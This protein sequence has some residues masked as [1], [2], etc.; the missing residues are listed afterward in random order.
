MAELTHVH[1]ED[2]A[3]SSDT[4]ST[5][6]LTISGAS[7]TANTKYLAICR[8]LGG[9]DN[10]LDRHVWQL[11]SVDDASLGAYL[12]HSVEA[13]ENTSTGLHA[14]FLVR[15][16]KT[17]ASPGDVTLDVSQP[18]GG[19]QYTDQMSLVLLD[20]DAIGESGHWDGSVTD[21]DGV[22]TNDSNIAD[23]DESTL[24]SVATTGTATTNEIRI[25]G[26]THPTS[27]DVLLPVTVQFLVGITSASVV[28]FEI[29]D[30]GD[31]LVSGTFVVENSGAN[32]ETWSAPINIP[33]PS[34]GWTAAKMEGLTAVVW[35]STGTGTL[36]V[37]QVDFRTGYVEHIAAHYADL[38]NTDSG[39]DGEYSST[40]DTTIV[41]QL[42]GAA[43]G[44]DEYLILGG[45]KVN[46]N[47]AGRWYSHRLHA[48]Y[49][50]STA[51]VRS[52]VQAEGEDTS[53]ER[54]SGFAIRHK[55]SSGTPDV[56][57]YG[58]EEAANANH[59]DF[60][61]YLIALPTS[62]FA[63]FVDDYEAGS[64]VIDG[65]ETTIATT[66]SYTPTVTGN[67]LIFGRSNGVGPP[68]ALGGMWVE[69]TTTEIRTGDS[70]P[71]QN[72][73]WDDTKDQEQQ[74]T[75][76]RYA[77]TTAETFNL[78]SQ[79][80]GVDFDQEHRWLIVVNLNPPGAG[81]TTVTP[82]VITSTSTVPTPT[83][84]AAAKIVL[85]T[86]IIA[87]SLLP[88]PTA[89]A[90][91]IVNP[92]AIVSTS[93]VPTPT[94]LAAATV[95]P[96]VITSTGLL[97]TPTASAE[98]TTDIIQSSF[99]WRD[100]DPTGINAN[101][102]GD[103]AAAKD[104]DVTEP[105]QDIDPV[106]GRVRIGLRNLSGG[107]ID[108]AYELQYSKDGGSWQIVPLMADPWGGGSVQREVGLA[109]SASFVNG[110]ATTE[111]LSD[112][113][114][115][116]AGEGRETNPTGSI[117]LLT[118]EDTEL[119][120]KLIFRK[121]SQDGHAGD[122]TTFDFRVRD[123]TAGQLLGTYTEIPRLTIGNQV[124]HIGGAFVE[125]PGRTL[126]AD[127]DGNL[128]AL[129]EPTD[130]EGG[131]FEN[132]LVITKSA[133]GG[134]SWTAPDLANRPGVTFQD[135]E[136]GDMHY[137]AADDRIYIGWHTG[138]TAHYVEF[139][140]AGH[141]SPDEYGTVE[142]ID[143][144]ITG[145]GQQTITI[146]RRASDGVTK[147]I[148]S[149]H[150]GTDQRLSLKS[151]TSGGTWDGSPTDV[152]GEAAPIFAIGG[153]WAEIDS[154]NVIHMI[155]AL[156]PG[157]ATDGV[158]YH[159]EISTG[160]SLSG[161]TQVNDGGT[162]LDGN[163]LQW[164]HPF[165]PPV[166]YND[167]ATEKIA[168]LIY[169]S[170]NALHFTESPLDTISFITDEAVSDSD[171]AQN[172]GTNHMV[173]AALAVDDVDDEFIAVWTNRSDKTL[174]KT[175][176][177][178]SAGSWGTD[179]TELDAPFDVAWER[180]ITFTHSSGNGGNRVVGIMYDVHTSP[181]GTGG[182]KY[183]E[184]IRG[185]AD[186]TV[187][188]GV[189]VS[190][191]AVPTPTIL[192]AATVTPNAIVSTSLVPTP[193][194]LAAATVT[195]GAI[196]SVGLLPTPTVL[197]AA[198]V[199]PGT[200]VSTSGAPTPTIETATTVL[201]GTIV[202][203]SLVPT[204]TILAAALVT[205][206]VIGSTSTIPQPAVLAAATVTPNAIVSDSL[207]PTPTI[208][209][210]ATVTPGAIGSTTTIPT[211]T[212][213]AAAQVAPSAVVS[214]SLLPTP[215]IVSGIA[216]SP[217]VVVSTSGI[218]GPAVSGEVLMV[219]AVIIS[220]STI[221]TPTIFAQARLEPGVVVSVTTAPTPTIL[222]GALVTPAA[223]VAT[224]LI[225]TPT[226][227]AAATI[228]PGAIVSTSTL[229][230]PT[231]VI[232]S[233]TVNPDTIVSTSG[234]TAPALAAGA[235]LI[236]NVVASTS[237]LPTPLIVIPGLAPHPASIGGHIRLVSGG[238]AGELL[239]NLQFD[240]ATSTEIVGALNELV[241]KAEKEFLEVYEDYIAGIE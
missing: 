30:G 208:L 166:I 151:R 41:A 13:Q 103:W 142:E 160:D 163:G 181:G 75:F 186:T 120:F 96:G 32:E 133:D 187:T 156:L 82:G 155:Y 19:T 6:V 17:D 53:E 11:N 116:T 177:R 167:G 191:S 62:L 71:T 168:T 233:V 203:D 149:D 194:I 101:A 52:L 45:A 145:G 240:G 115:F 40:V 173:V 51:A 209:A 7:L 109:P 197:A 47:S 90:T 55:A 138:S 112:A 73:A 184:I 100:T 171:A 60:G 238:T 224:S 218:P 28:G 2:N 178:T 93:L 95:T 72:Q 54:I 104:V 125:T 20:L 141:A 196:D 127:D 170:G 92:I 198:T 130:T 205:P 234:I 215:T 117:E 80:P 193:T 189:V 119:E 146:I 69:S 87:T 132:E 223:V 231:I 228:V 148:Y 14:G 147:A 225:P 113:G 207:M 188:P 23:G 57:L 216:V 107:T 213:L 220:D 152:D 128:Y 204:P 139:N 35:L 70:T 65:T 121:W 129:L 217:D 25:A 8:F 219:V 131:T 162:L 63:D 85:T 114:T 88:T 16:F 102:G 180:V 86:A 91:T 235:N 94:I 123:V 39:G 135:L 154:N 97:P 105:I 202:S 214:T 22:W 61:A 110:A 83:I 211:V 58:T 64:V 158:L 106:S 46:V 239:A 108:V 226:V 175:D 150:D 98:D 1:V 44:T 174:M 185:G 153:A 24:A 124:G 42:P 4:T 59:S 126:V 212:I 192:A 199:T 136:A 179:V 229:P 164:L 232:A 43:L 48:A 190:T 195:P 237:T 84:T 172:M 169:D 66:G 15:S 76:Q 206:G 140:T 143:G 222:A 89:S 12:E 27:G 37:H 74:V 77:I 236:P 81:D 3:L 79:A 67:H 144:S 118:G 99:R 137:I 210:A 134:V 165:V 34:G 29:L 176:V 9:G 182:I 201:P 56:T 38:S 200:I 50:T 68:T 26:N 157:G 159:R 230:T 21:N 18:D 227:L 31:S 122:G 10:G 78:R 36:N 241:A 5:S 33:A 221:P 49:D 183:R 111:I 161:R